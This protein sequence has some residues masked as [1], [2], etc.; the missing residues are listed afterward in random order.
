VADRLI[1]IC[2][3][4]G[5]F[6]PCD[7][8][9][10][11]CPESWACENEPDKAVDFYVLAVDFERVKR[12]RDEMRRVRD[13]WV[14]LFNQLQDAVSEAIERNPDDDALAAAYAAVRRREPAPAGREEANGG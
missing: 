3:H 14:R 4:H 8:T 1:G 9:D 10:E 12:E 7:S 2:R 6:F 11:K 13:R 5:W